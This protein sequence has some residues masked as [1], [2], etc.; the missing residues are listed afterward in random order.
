MPCVVF[1][2]LGSLLAGG[3]GEGDIGDFLYLHDPCNISISTLQL[4]STIL[5]DATFISC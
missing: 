3:V 1:V 4:Y 2:S 5:E